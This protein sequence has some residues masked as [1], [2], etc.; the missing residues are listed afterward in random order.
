MREFLTWSP[1][2][3]HYLYHAGWG[4]LLLKKSEK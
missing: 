2:V 3:N 4:A 1:Y